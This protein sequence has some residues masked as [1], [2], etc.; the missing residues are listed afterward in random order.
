MVVAA[1]GLDGCDKDSKNRR[2]LRESTTTSMA[3]S[4]PNDAKGTETIS[5]AAVKLIISPAPN[6][7]R[8]T[9]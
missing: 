3:S 6:S 4:E 1:G 2:V 5:I 7:H 9:A 8:G